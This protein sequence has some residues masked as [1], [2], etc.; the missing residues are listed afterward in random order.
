MINEIVCVE[1]TDVLHRD[2]LTLSEVKQLK[3]VPAISYGKLLWM[4]DSRVVVVS[5]IFPDPDGD[6]YR[7]CSSIPRCLVT[8]LTKMEVKNEVSLD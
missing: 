1:W 8:K 6:E 4:D 5:T 3:P 2:D 7:D